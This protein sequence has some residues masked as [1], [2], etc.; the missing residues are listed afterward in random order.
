MTDNRPMVNVRIWLHLSEQHCKE[1][2]M[3]VS[4]FS[5]FL[6]CIVLAVF[7]DS[8][9][10]FIAKIRRTSD[11]RYISFVTISASALTLYFSCYINRVIR[12]ILRQ[13][14]MTNRIN[15]DIEKL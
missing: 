15:L 7:R 6:L 10:K 3:V 8:G 1:Q 9:S 12:P 2:M 5:E 11:S 13:I 4:S 14:I